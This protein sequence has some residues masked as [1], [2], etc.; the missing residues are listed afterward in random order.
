MG[1]DGTHYFFIEL[2][3]SDE[4]FWNKN[5]NAINSSIDCPNPNIPEMG[6][7][8]NE[9]IAGST[10]KGIPMMERTKKVILAQFFPFPII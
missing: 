8:N 4:L 5:I 1:G 3:Q 6:F 9:Y 2:N 7:V 10:E